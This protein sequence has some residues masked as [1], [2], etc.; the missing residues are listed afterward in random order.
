MKEYIGQRCSVHILIRKINLFFDAEVT[1]V[2]D[3]H[4]SFIDKYKRGYSFRIKD[5]VE[6]SRR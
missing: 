4:I 2:S 3:T 1:E 5:V 6:I